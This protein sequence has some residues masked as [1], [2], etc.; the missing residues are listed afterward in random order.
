MNSVSGDLFVTLSDDAV[1]SIRLTGGDRSWKCLSCLIE[2]T[3][4]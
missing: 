2:G 3:K 1:V 4:R